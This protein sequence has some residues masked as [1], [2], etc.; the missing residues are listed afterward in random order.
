MK[1]CV[2][3]YDLE[4]LEKVSDI[5]K[6]FTLSCF[7]KCYFDNLEDVQFPTLALKSKKLTLKKG[8]L[9]IN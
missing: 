8:G 6:H 5:D 2:P 4:N 1:H 3:I 9:L 7:L